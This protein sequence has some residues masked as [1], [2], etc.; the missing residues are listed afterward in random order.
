MDLFNLLALGKKPEIVKTCFSAA[1][2]GVCTGIATAET[3]NPAVTAKD[4]SEYF[5]LEALCFDNSS[6]TF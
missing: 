4:V 5:V 3:S 1:T 2:A 6:S